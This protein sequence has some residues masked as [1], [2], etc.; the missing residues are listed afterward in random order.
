MRFRLWLEND[1]QSW[2]QGSKVV[3]SKDRPKRVFHGT[4]NPSFKTF[5]LNAP[6]STQHES[7]T[8]GIWFTD[9][10][11]VATKFAH[12]FSNNMRGRV[13]AVYLK[14]TNPKIYSGEDGFE[15]MMDDRSNFIIN[16]QETNQAFIQHLKSQGHDGIIIL[17]TEWD[18]YRGAKM[19]N[20]GGVSAFKF[21]PAKGTSNQYIVF[22]PNQIRKATD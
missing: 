9:D 20:R 13:H 12:D 3:D 8:I 15:S 21:R 22:D 19:R 16:P 4:P 11:L 6:R 14:I 17:H 7:G 18:A 5:K 1:L 2:F 10:P